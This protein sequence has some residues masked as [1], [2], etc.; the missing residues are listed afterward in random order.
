MNA[1]PTCEAAT[2]SSV[3]AAFGAPAA[4][5]KAA[6]DSVKLA[7]PNIVAWK[8]RTW[9]HSVLRDLKSAGGVRRFRA[10]P[11]VLGHL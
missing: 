5:E 10:T 2:P 7:V 1:T 3:N 11:L 4:V 8:D 6:E 9:P